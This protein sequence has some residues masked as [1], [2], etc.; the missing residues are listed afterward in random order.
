MHHLWVGLERRLLDW[1]VHLWRFVTLRH[2]RQTFLKFVKL[3]SSEWPL[4]G[5]LAGRLRLSYNLRI[6]RSAAHIQTIASL[7][8]ALHDNL[9]INHGAGE[10]LSV[11]RLVLPR[12]RIYVVSLQVLAVDE[13]TRGGSSVA[14]SIGVES[15]FAEVGRHSRVWEQPS[16]QLQLLKFVANAAPFLRRELMRSISG[17]AIAILS[18]CV[19][20]STST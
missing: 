15:R 2:H 14:V 6:W 3:G 5:S 16:I 17:S 1:N 4:E 11:L 9:R 7:V 8:R 18:G 19:F 12:V 13:A 20:Q 10:D